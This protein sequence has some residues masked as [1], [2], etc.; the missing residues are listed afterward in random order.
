MTA[1]STRRLRFTQGVLGLVLLAVALS[2]G[3]AWQ[4]LA[5]V[6]AQS[7]GFVLVAGATLWRVWSSLFIAGRKD[8]EIV[9]EG[10]YGRCRHP[11]YLGSLVAA[12]GIGLT[13][14][15]LALTALLPATI[16]AAL[17]LSIRHEEA[18]LAAYHGDRW[19]RYCERVPWRLLPRPGP[20]TLPPHRE[21]DVLVFRKAF[22]DAASMLGLWLLVLLLDAMRVQLAWPTYFRLP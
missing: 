2:G 11:L 1:A 18:T 17:L 3:R 20:W 22:L 7:L 6:L 19:R 14:R 21:I 16:A 15:S 10:P 9:D 13:T 8:L 4:G 5:G 12:I